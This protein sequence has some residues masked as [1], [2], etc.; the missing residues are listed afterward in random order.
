MVKK[1]T[2]P[3][4]LRIILIPQSSAPAA[5]VLIL[6]EAGSEYETKNINGLSH[7]LEHMTFKG[8]TNR[9]KP[10]MV[11]RELDGLGAQSNAFTG[12]EYTGYW[13]KV[14][15]HKVDKILDIVSDLYLN[16]IFNQAE[17]DK[18]RGV[19]IEEINLYEDTPPRRVQELFNSLL[20]GDQ[21]AGWD[22]GG[23]KEVIRKVSRNDFV[24]YRS[25]HYVASKTIVVVA[26]GFNEKKVLAQIKKD[27]K[28]LPRA[29]RVA[30]FAT[31]VPHQ[32]RPAVLLKHKESDQSHLVLGSHAFDVFDSRRYALDV[33]NDVLGGG[34][35]SRLFQRVREELGA[36]YYI[37][38]GADL[39]LDH[40][41][42]EVS[43]G[44][45]HTKIDQV[46][47]AIVEELRKLTQVLVGKEELQKAKDHLTGNLLLSLEGSDDLANFYG[48]QEILTRNLET[49]E[50][51]IQKLQK[52]SADEIR[53][54]ARAIF[55][56]ETLNLAIIGPYKKVTNF[57]KL[58]KF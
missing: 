3:N 51:M 26:G 43:S 48:G 53:R 39:M 37:R 47:R 2:L 19:V 10:G 12:Q 50:H 20:Y 29:R 42:F 27:F 16:P 57:T 46:I 56:P 30:K 14:Q 34:M 55:K 44:V 25:T 58:L 23:R 4:G 21:P 7:F 33:L 5:T 41:Y 45:D 24:K 38:S 36:A 13:A 18:E 22:I 1:L 11:S 54:L 52:V 32:K 17:I 40:G 6:V 9:P 35:S 15:S 49:P 8:T 28:S 31:R